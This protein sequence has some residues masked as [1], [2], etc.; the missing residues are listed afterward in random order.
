M[1]VNLLL[2]F[3]AGVIGF[4]SPCVLPLI[5]GYVAYVSG[6][7]LA[8]LREG[9]RRHLGR[10]V[11]GSLLFVLGFSIMFTAIGASASTIGGFI[12]E[13]RL[14]ITRI[15]G[16][17]VIVLGLVVLGVLRV[18]ALARERRLEALPRVGLAGAV[19]LGMAFGF[20][21]IPCVGPVLAAVLTLAATTQ[22]TGSGALLLFTYAMGLGVPF[23]ATAVLLGTATG[24]LRWLGR[25]G[26]AIEMASGAFL[27]VMGAAMASDTLFM[28]NTWIIRVLR[29]QPP[30]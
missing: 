6:V 11:V 3:A 27:V 10:V 9:G 25:H 23:L 13:N 26:R 18:P 15:A 21:W 28:L 5:P 1:E 24:L 29:F 4:A 22:N 17:V 2:A 12:S 16:L 8:E 7:S 14:L 30:L 19:P 20:A